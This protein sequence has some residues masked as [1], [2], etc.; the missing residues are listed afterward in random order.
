MKRVLR[1]FSLPSYLREMVRHLRLWWRLLKDPRVPE[2]LKLL[3]PALA[4]VYVLWPVDLL[5]D[6]VPILG[7]LDDVAVMLLALRLFE[8]LAPRAVVAE[9]LAN[10]R[11]RAA[12]PAS[13][14][15][16]KRPA[17]HDD[18]EAIDV[19]YRVL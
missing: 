19:E 12:S 3:L 16:G 13:P 17:H 9:H 4:V 2:T 14:E 15:T 11:A 6:L 18:A 10:L 5:P 8:N 7:Q 1:P